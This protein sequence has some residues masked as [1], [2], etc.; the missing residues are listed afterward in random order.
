[1]TRSPTWTCRRRNDGSLCLTNNPNVKQKCVKCGAP[2]PKRRKPAHMVA[3]AIPYETYV[4]LNAGDHC[5]ICLRR[6]TEDDRK[7]DRDHDHRTGMPR[8]LLCHK[9]NRAL[10]V[11]VTPEWLR[12]AADY[13]ERSAA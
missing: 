1:M 10:Q 11:W 3:L 2:R 12:A 8:G 7:F 6:R 9:C 4:E 13:L 5:S